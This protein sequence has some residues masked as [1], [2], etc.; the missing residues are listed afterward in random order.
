MLLRPAIDASFWTV[1]RRFAVLFALV[2]AWL[3][4]SKADAD[5]PLQ[6]LLLAPSDAEISVRVRG[7]TRDLPLLLEVAEADEPFDRD[8]AERLGRERAAHVVVWSEPSGGRNL[9]VYVLDLS[10]AALRVRD[11]VAPAREALAASTTAEIAALVVRSE[12]SGLLAERDAALARAAALAADAAAPP[13]TTVVEPPAQPAPIQRSQ[14][15]APAPAKGRERPWLL[16]AGYRASRPLSRALSHAGTLTLRR[17]LGSFALGLSG[18]AAGPLE[19]ADADTR[20]RLRRFGM[21]GE[22]LRGLALGP[23]ARL[24]FGAALGCAGTARTTH[25]V[26]QEQRPTANA[27]SW[28]GNVG[29]SGELHW[30]ALPFF[31]LSLA[32]GV[33]FVL[34]RTKF[35][36]E[37]ADGRQPLNALSRFDPWAIAGLFTRFGS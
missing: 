13:V 5:A 7:Q 19:L 28:S 31:G 34:W 23:R 14:K 27:V 21:R 6:V 36:Y 29:V 10:S 35:A 17:D 32:L 15:A 22:A 12:L 2:A 20:V 25:T 3:L 26:G 16:G 4:A 37:D 30:Q 24:W 33:D 1:R 11:V 9:R 18:Y 8:E